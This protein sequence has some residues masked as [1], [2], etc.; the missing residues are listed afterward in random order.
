MILSLDLIA[1]LKKNILLSNEF[2][3]KLGTLVEDYKVHLGILEKSFTF[4]FLLR[5]FSYSVVLVS[6]VLHP[7]LQ[8]QICI[9]TLLIPVII[10]IYII[11]LDA[12][13]ADIYSAI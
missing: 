10:Y 1:G 3:Q 13:M 9:L 2:Q 8:L 11:I 4:I 5:R 6:L 7:K 12:P